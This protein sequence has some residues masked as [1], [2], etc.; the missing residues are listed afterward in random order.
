MTRAHERGENEFTE[1]VKREAARAGAP[2]SEILDRMLA[3]AIEGRDTARQQKIVRAE[4]Y[5]RIRNR[6]KRGGR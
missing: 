1:A 3:E 4:K 5:L 2:V 6:R